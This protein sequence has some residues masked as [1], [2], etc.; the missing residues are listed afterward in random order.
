MRCLMAI[1]FLLSPMAAYALEP[2]EFHLFGVNA[3][4]EVFD[5]TPFSGSEVA[6]GDPE[7]E[8]GISGIFFS[9][10][11]SKGKAN[12]KSV[13]VGKCKVRNWKTYTVSCANGKGIFAGSVYSGQKVTK[14]SLNNN[15]DAKALHK[16]F[17][18]RNDY[19]SIAAYYR[20]KSGCDPKLPTS[21]IFM[22]Y[23]D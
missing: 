11:I 19:G 13:A 7:T 16:S 9:W 1:F 17:I 4:G 23:G 8:D 14:A 2:I 21:L 3:T 12:A 6:K 20:C 22:W 18:S 10:D 5:L 15:P